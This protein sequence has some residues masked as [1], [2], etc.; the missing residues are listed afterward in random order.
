MNFSDCIDH[1]SGVIEYSPNGN[2]V[3]IAKGFDINV[4]SPSND[5]IQLLNYYRSMKPHIYAQ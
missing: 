4:S 5:L 2:L 1:S 3:A